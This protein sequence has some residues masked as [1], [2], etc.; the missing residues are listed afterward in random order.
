MPGMAVNG[1]RVAQGVGVVTLAVGTVLAIAPVTASRRL[2]LG[3]HRAGVRAVGL[4]DLALV[5]GLLCGRP[6][7]PWMA[8]R[9]ALNLLIA[10]YTAWLAQREGSVASRI[11]TIALVGL[12]V[13]DTKLALRLRAGED[14]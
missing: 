12:T 5:P 9:A 14:R 4:A 11:A 7:W 8:A 2:R 3:D 6:R 1:E 13:P 10:A